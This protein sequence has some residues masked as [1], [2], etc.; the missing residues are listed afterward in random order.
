MQKTWWP[1]DRRVR[2]LSLVGELVETHQNI[3]DLCDRL[4]TH[5]AI[6]EQEQKDLFNMLFTGKKCAWCGA[7][8]TEEEIENSD[9]ICYDCRASIDWE[10]YYPSHPDRRG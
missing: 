6:L 8:M 7:I 4:A 10:D 9:E 5:G 2:A 1:E 3:G